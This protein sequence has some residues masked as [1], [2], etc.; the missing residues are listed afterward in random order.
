MLSIILVL[1][2]VVV[3]ISVTIAVKVVSSLEK[4]IKASGKNPEDVIRSVY[5]S[6]SLITTVLNAGVEYSRVMGGMK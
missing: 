5:E 6:K 3:L 1:F 2:T 4:Q